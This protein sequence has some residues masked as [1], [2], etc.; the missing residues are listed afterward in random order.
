MNPWLERWQRVSAHEIKLADGGRRIPQGSTPPPADVIAGD[1]CPA[2]GSLERWQTPGG[3]WICRPCLIRGDP[4]ISAIQVWS[5]VLGEVVW[6]VADQLPQAEWPQDAPVYTQTEV[7]LLTQVGSGT[8]A[9]VHAVKEL[10]RA[11]VAR[12]QKGSGA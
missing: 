1:P 10:F 3:R 8:L 11:R 4:P 2:C 9:W 7:T 12:A 5:A 6:V